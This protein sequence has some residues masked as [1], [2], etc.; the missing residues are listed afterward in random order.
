[1]PRCKHVAWKRHPWLC[2]PIL[3]ALTSAAAAQTPTP[4]LEAF[5]AIYR[6]LIEIDTTDATGDTLEAAQAMAARLQAAGFPATDIRVVST[7]PKKGNLVARLHG[8]GTRKPILL[9]AHIDVVPP[10]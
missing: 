3:A 2:L 4:Q 8:S 1:M 5:R 10:G 6:E 9:L 7:G